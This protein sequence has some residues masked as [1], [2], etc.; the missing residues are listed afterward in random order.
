MKKTL[1]FASLLFAGSS[2]AQTF[3]PT[4]EPVIGDANSMYLCDSFVTNYAG[5]SGSGVTWDYSNIQKVD[6]EMKSISLIDPTATIN[7]ADYPS[8]N[9]NVEVQGFFST[10]WETNATER[11]SVGFVYN[12]PT[13]GE[14]KAVFS[15][16][17]K[18]VSYDFNLNDVVSDNYAGTLSFEFNG[19]PLSPA[20]TGTVYSKFDGIGTLK[21]NAATTLTD[22]QRIVMHDTL[23]ALIASPFGNFQIKFVRAQYEY[24]HFATSKLPVF[25]HSTGIMTNDTNVVGAFTVVLS[26][27]E[28]DN[29][30]AV[31]NTTVNNF[32]VYPNPV[33]TDLTIAGEFTQADAQIVNQAGQVVK[34]ITGVTPGTIIDMT[35]VDKGLYFLNL[36]INGQNNVQKIIKE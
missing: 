29:V 16:P 28:P 20:C 33:K 24:Y 31:S 5:V 3:T 23:D 34:T 9:K 15:N 30:L 8:S 36:N 4:N 32:K 18:L 19:I 27:F 25:T 7:S 14:V 11:N 21:L 6:G 12:E 1:L 13:F 10:Y 17:A 26:A 22:V 35:N 2:F